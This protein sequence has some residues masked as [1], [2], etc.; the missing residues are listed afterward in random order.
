MIGVNF[1]VQSIEQL[2]ANIKGQAAKLQAELDSLQSACQRDPSF[3]GSAANSYDDYM[4]KWHSS[5]QQLM[6]ALNG[7]G[8][9]LKSLADRLNQENQSVTSVFN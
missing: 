2:A 3:T 1:P 4:Q 9:V 8:G 5:Q 6:E 7:A